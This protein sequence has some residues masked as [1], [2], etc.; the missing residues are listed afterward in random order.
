MR[1]AADYDFPHLTIPSRHTIT[2]PDKVKGIPIVADTHCGA[3]HGINPAETELESGSTYI[4]HKTGLE[5][6][7][8][9]D[10]C[11]WE[12]L[13][14]VLRVKKLQNACFDVV[15]VGDFVDGKK[16][17]EFL[18]STEIMDQINSAFDLFFPIV[19]AARAFH[20][21]RGTPAHDGRA[22]QYSETLAARFKIP[23][24]KHSG[25]RTH[26]CLTIHWRKH[27]I[28]FYHSMGTGEYGL[29]ALEK[30][31]KVAWEV[32]GRWGVE[33]PHVIVRAHR[34]DYAGLWTKVGNNHTFYAVSCPCWKL[35]N[36]WLH[37]KHVPKQLLPIF[38]ILCITE[39]R[40][41]RLVIHDMTKSLA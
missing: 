18:I 25:T 15:H 39:D 20:I 14:H 19:D 7:K 34:H 9:W 10:F 3:K 27:R 11:W 41:G 1:K 29:R 16:H 28:Q 38:G 31:A 12:W 24:A 17:P 36:D 26:K 13:P 21:I 33:A 4:P 8:F 5:L 35:P 32:A 30:E 23:R 40:F 2:I 6:H 22:G 37:D